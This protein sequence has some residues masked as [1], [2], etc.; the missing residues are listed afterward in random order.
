MSRK[1]I[2]VAL[3]SSL[4]LDFVLAYLFYNTY[5]AALGLLPVSAIYFYG[6]WNQAC[7]KRE[8]RFREQFQNSLQIKAS[9][10]RTGYSVE[11]A[12]RETE[13]ELKTLYSNETRICE[14]YEQ[15][16]RG[17]NMNLTAEQVLRE[18]AGRVPQEDVVQLV[19]VFV[20]SKRMGGDGIGILKE[21][22]RILCGKAET[23]REIE[24]LIAA[25][26]FE[27]RLM[28][29]IPLGMILYMRF[30]FPQFLSVLYGNVF[31]VLVMSSCLGMYMFAYQL[32]NR[33][34]RIEV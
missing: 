21:S 12:I 19:T 32:G 10:L 5:W 27:F 29:V 20:A 34:T 28:C 24:T 14:E 25:K 18:L 4:G 1:E 22:I 9:M 13:K 11:N 26:R 15:M 7:H 31:G 30:A 33:M 17:L 16:S 6:W 2:V 8:L 23:E 3:A